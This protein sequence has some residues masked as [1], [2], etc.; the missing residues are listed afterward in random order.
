MENA[1]SV[2]TDSRLMSSRR[3]SQ[4]SQ[5][6]IFSARSSLRETVN[7]LEHNQIFVLLMV[8][9]IMSLLL[10]ASEKYFINSK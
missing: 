4:T 7:F 10:L 9:A 1:N 5:F 2:I 6:M 8:L 3:S